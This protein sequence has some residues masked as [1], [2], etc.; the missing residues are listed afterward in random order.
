MDKLPLRYVLE[1]S[2]WKIFYLSAFPGTAHLNQ[3]WTRA[4]KVGWCTAGN[5]LSLRAWTSPVKGKSCVSP[6]EHLNK[7]GHST[8]LSSLW[9]NHMAHLL[10]YLW[11]F[12]N[13]C[14]NLYFSSEFAFEWYEDHNEVW[15][16]K[17]K[18]GI[19][20]RLP[21]TAPTLAPSGTPGTPDSSSQ[22]E[23]CRAFV[24]MVLRG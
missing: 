24:P 12:S 13:S 7:Q 1:L 22:P 23:L 2:L 15:I 14:F 5:L 4:V 8:N 11:G 17:E 10:C 6:C 9:Y 18:P 3:N 20:A 19:P 21:N 16:K